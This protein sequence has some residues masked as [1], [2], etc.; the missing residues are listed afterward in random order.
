MKHPR[1]I[2]NLIYEFSKLPTVGPKT[3]ER[4]VFYLLKKSQD[5]LNSLAQAVIDLKKNIT[6]CQKCLSIAEMSPCHICSDGSRDQKTLC[7]VANTRDLATIEATNQYHGLYFVLGGVLN[8]IEGIKPETLNINQLIDK[9]KNNNF[10]E[11][12]LAFNPNIEGET[13]SLYL[14]KI[15]KDHKVKVTRLAKGLPMGADLEYADEM[16]LTNALKYRNEL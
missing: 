9:I 13:T 12:I 11:I 1:S 8:A 6:V 2:Q 7:L 5:E 3:A 14:T 15:I 10:S 16:T 4:F